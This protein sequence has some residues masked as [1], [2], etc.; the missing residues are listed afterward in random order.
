MSR[1]RSHISLIFTGNGGGD[2]NPMIPCYFMTDND[3]E[4]PYFATVLIERSLE[5]EITYHFLKSGLSFALGK[6][7]RAV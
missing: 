6:V 2:K 3:K 7:Q 1:C 4:I 5:A